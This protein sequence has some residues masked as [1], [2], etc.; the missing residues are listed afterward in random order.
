M[1]SHP[2]FRISLVAATFL[3]TLGSANAASNLVVNGGFETLT[4]GDA[5]IVPGQTTGSRISSATGWYSYSTASNSGY[6]FLFFATNAVTT[7]FADA[8]DNGQ[9]YLWGASNGGANTWD[10][11]SAAGGHFLVM[12]G[13]YHA[14]A[15]S[16]NIAGLVTGM[17]YQLSFSWAAAQWYGITGAITESI[18]VSLGNQVK[19]TTTYNLASTGFSGWMTTTMNFTYDGTS[20]VLSFLAV[21]GPSGLPPIALLDGIS[22]SAVAEPT[23]LAGLVVGLVILGGSG[24]FSLRRRRVQIA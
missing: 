2:C 13:D 9:R 18:Q 3:L 21:G 17:S 15:I 16:Q 20:S 1:T 14:T 6:P 10:G 8:W 22:L 5:E 19:S 11:T 24:A 12:D 7:G 4:N 23:S